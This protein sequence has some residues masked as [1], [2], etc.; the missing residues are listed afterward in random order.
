MKR[1]TF[2]TTVVNGIERT[3]PL[4]A[5]SVPYHQLHA[6]AIDIDYLFEAGSIIGGFLSLLEDI[7]DISER[8]RSL[9][10]TS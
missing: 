9:A 5:S 6:L 1:R 4:L 2:G 3:I 8:E 10:D 7:L